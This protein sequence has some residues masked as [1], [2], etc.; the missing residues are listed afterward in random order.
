MRK[1]AMFLGFLILAFTFFGVSTP[2]VIADGDV[3]LE[4]TQIIITTLYA[5]ANNSVTVVVANNGTD[6]VKDFDLNLEAYNSA[7][8][9]TTTMVKTQTDNVTPYWPAF[10]KFNWVPAESGNYT[11]TATVDPSDNIT[12]K[13]KTNNVL[14]DNV[15]VI[16]LT[17]VN[18]KVRV[19]GS[20][21][22]IWSGNV[23]FSNSTITDKEDNDVHTF[24]YPTA[25]GALDEASRAGG[26]S[27]VVTSSLYV[28]EV[29][30]EAEVLASPWP[31]WKFR[32]DWADSSVGAAD[33]ALSENDIEVLWY[34]GTWGGSQPLRLTLDNS[35][36]YP[37]NLTALVEYYDDTDWNPLSDATLHAGERIYTTDAKGE[38]DVSLP[39]G[40]YHVFADKGDYTQFTRSNTETAIVYVTLTIQ[41]GWNFISIPKKLA[42]DNCTASEVFAGIDTDSRPIL[43]CTSGGWSEMSANSTVSPLE[44]IWIYSTSTKELRPQFDPNPQQI[45]PTKQLWAGW[46]AIGFSDFTAAPANS[47]L[48][49]VESKWSTLIGYDSASQ[50]Y[51][52]SIINNDITGGPHNE[53]QDMYPWKGYWLYMTS[54]GELAAISS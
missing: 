48:T 53:G 20:T 50:T 19:E 8:N 11:L 29:A 38:V 9:T 13:D 7:T 51:D 10:L 46:N 54:A 25:L 6:N 30:G 2:Q 43:Q 15:T 31:G 44:G 36:P 32:V 49:S 27:Y 4:P 39:P 42:S 22:T 34:Y 16:D 1:V 47:T 26:F 12:E 17:S 5:S 41:P 45:P 14:T 40:L 24:N 35:I 3:D 37:D 28:E 33:Y 18:V 52:P 23:T 21:S